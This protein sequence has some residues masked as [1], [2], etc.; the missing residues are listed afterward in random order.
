MFFVSSSLSVCVL[1]RTRRKDIY[2]PV[3]LYGQ[4]ARHERGTKLLSSLPYLA[5]MFA[6][7]QSADNL[8]DLLLKHTKAALWAAVCFEFIANLNTII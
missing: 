2:V 1:S 7:L 6:Y 5:D 3:H 4:L 8:N